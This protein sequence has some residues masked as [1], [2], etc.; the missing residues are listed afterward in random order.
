MKILLHSVFLSVFL[1]A[2]YADDL[3]FKVETE[4]SIAFNHNKSLL[5]SSA[6]EASNKVT[7]SS[8][9][10]GTIKE[11]VFSKG[12]KIKK[13]S[14]VIKTDNFE[15]NQKLFNEGLLSRFEFEKQAILSPIEG[16]LLGDHKVVG[17]FIRVGDPVYSLVDL[18]EI[19]AIGYL[20]EIQINEIMNASE[21]QILIN[22]LIL[23]GKISYVSPSAET[24]SR[25]FK[26][27]V[28]SSN[29]D[30]EQVRDGMTAEIKILLNN[31]K[32]HKISPSI[33]S[34]NEKGELTVKT[35]S[36]E[37]LVKEKTI[38]IEEDTSEYT[39]ISGLS[40]KE[41][42]IINGHQFVEDGQKVNF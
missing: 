30:I 33:L 41:K 3:L 28:T 36:S 29:P 22:N 2:S 15:I 31:T 6:I 18:R 21:V 34:L 40:E 5:V 1:F 16:I 27:E 19:K 37:G 25:T 24:S 38:L 35:I 32:V 20:N 4:D 11:V 42:I 23:N 9:I 39:L 14:V 26:I 17:D 13:G 7:V 10:T 12:T 8:E